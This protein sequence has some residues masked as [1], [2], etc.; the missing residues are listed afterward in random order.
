MWMTP[1]LSRCFTFTSS[2]STRVRPSLTF[3]FAFG[4]VWTFDYASGSS[5]ADDQ[6]A[7]PDGELHAKSVPSGDFLIAIEGYDVCSLPRATWTP[8]H[9]RS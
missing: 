9:L 8:R 5:R 6:D 3:D 7:V 1:T 4:S 2:T